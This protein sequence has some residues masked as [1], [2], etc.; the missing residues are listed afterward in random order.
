M[1]ATS[2]GWQPQRP[3]CGAGTEA[4]AA[5]YTTTAP[6]AERTFVRRVGGAYPTLSTRDHDI[7]IHLLR[8]PDRSDLRRTDLLRFGNRHIGTRGAVHVRYTGGVHSVGRGCFARGGGSV[9]VGRVADR[10]SELVGDVAGDA[11]PRRV[12]TVYRITFE[13]RSK[14][15]FQ[16]GSAIPV[17]FKVFDQSGQ[18]VTAV[19]SDSGC[20]VSVER[21]A[22]CG[23]S[24][25]LRSRGRRF[26]GPTGGVKTYPTLPKG[27][28]HAITSRFCCGS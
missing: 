9:H 2:P 12:G 20:A 13:P 6:T 25:A 18:P 3:P 22:L 8:D 17:K 11:K 26:T 7:A 16:R 1:R 5:G 14:S 24:A 4:P 10:R 23:R 27:A 19:G 28:D 15:T 21:F